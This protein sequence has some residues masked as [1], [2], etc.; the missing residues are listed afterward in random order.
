MWKLKFL[1]KETSVINT[2]ETLGFERS[3]RSNND[4]KIIRYQAKGFILVRFQA[5]ENN[6]GE[7]F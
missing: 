2:G 3:T 1:M 5:I 7:L 6:L 4:K